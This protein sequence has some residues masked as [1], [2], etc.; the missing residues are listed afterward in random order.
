MRNLYEVEHTGARDRL[1]LT[2]SL[3]SKEVGKVDYSLFSFS[4]FHFCQDKSKIIYADNLA[5]TVHS[6]F[7]TILFCLFD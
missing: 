7:N 6:C 3:V 5:Y 1:A 2:A 4:I